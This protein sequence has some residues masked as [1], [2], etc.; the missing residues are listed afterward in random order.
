MTDYPPPSPYVTPGPPATPDER[1]WALLS[2]LSIFALGII[3]PVIIMLT[4]GKESGFVRD[5]AVES[6]N[7]HITLAIATVVSAILVLV[8]VGILLLAVIAIAGPVLGIVGAI[9]AYNGEAYRYPLNL[10][11]VR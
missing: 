1:T 4:K 10:R 2:H 11:L 5:Q 9:R 8:L 7:F 3:A 6:L